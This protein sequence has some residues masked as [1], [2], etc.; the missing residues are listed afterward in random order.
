MNVE[1]FF[2]ARTN[3]CVDTLALL[4]PNNYSKTG[5]GYKHRPGSF[6][7]YLFF[8]LYTDISIGHACAGTAGYCDVFGKCR[9]VDAE[10]PLSR[11][12]NMLLS[13]ENIRTLTQIGQ[14][15][16]VVKFNIKTKMFVFFQEYWW[17]LVLGLLGLIGL[18][19]IFVKIC[20]VH[21]PSSNP[22]LK[23]ARSFSLKHRVSF[24]LIK[25]INQSLYFFKSHN[26][27]IPLPPTSIDIE[28]N[29]LR[30]P[31]PKIYVRGKSSSDNPNNN[32]RL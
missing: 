30:Q 11:L 4:M 1:S 9:A 29:S 3:S 20:S 12:K 6:I 26:P 2:I 13:E 14:V 10:G 28:L 25:M 8:D 22:R 17:A 21:T 23:P 7:D 15:C 18:M 31:Q 5:F 24:L 27:Q 16:V 19:S 32:S